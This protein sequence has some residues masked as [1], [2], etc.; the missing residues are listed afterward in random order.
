MSGTTSAGSPAARP[1]DSERRFAFGRNW[2][3]YVEKSFTPE[4]V[5][6][7][8]KHL[9]GFLGRTDLAGQSFLDIGCGSGLHSYAAFQAGAARVVSFDYDRDSVET[10]RLLH[11]VAGH[12]ERWSISQGSILDRA[13][14]ATLGTFDVVYS[15][16]VL[17]H[18]GDQWSAIRNA[19]SCLAPGS[20]FYI[21]LYTSD[22]F[23]DPPP[24]FWLDVKKRYV[25]G[26]FLTKRRLE[27]WYLWRFNLGG[28][29][30]RIPR[31]V[32]QMAE[33]KKNRGMNLYTD[34]KD[35]LGGW[36]MEFSSIAEVKRFADKELGLELVKI[37][38]GEANTEYLFRKPA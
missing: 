11:A 21:A 30:L 29:P 20:L 23:V 3:D 31:L 25:D 32:K 13:F 5:E 6:I 16:G 18:T 36:P 8:R 27:L 15:W 24:A 17:H 22:V 9:L 7:A 2:R 37:A 14:V 38:A 35:W 10:T 19:A 34:V 33:Y 26:G 1:P 4:K 12:P 28:N